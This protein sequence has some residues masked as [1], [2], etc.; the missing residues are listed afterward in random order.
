MDVLLIGF[1]AIAREVLKL[2]SPGEALNITGVL[3]RP[4]RIEEVRAALVGRDIEVVSA[5]DDLVTTP[6]L[7]AE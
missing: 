7:V 3:V 2:I 4:S 1:G 5:I 6:Q